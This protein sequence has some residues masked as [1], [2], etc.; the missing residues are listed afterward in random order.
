MEREKIQ[1]VVRNL[2]ALKTEA[3]PDF[4]REWKPSLEVCLDVIQNMSE[5]FN[6]AKEAPLEQFL[7]YLRRQYGFE[8]KLTSKLRCAYGG[9]CE[10]RNCAADGYEAGSS[11]ETLVNDRYWLD[12]LKPFI[13]TLRLERGNFK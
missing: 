13:D 8:I 6:C 4:I 1:D 3:L 11:T 12:G 5:N 7:Y 2:I 10:D 9:F